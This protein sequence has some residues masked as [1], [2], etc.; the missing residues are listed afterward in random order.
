MSLCPAPRNNAFSTNLDK[1]SYGDLNVG[2][3]TRGLGLTGSSLSLNIQMLEYFINLFILNII[4]GSILEEF[5][6]RIREKMFCTTQYGQENKEINLSL[7]IMYFPEL[8]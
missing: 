6:I 8:Y 4:I 3:R 5:Q 2:F 7:N 1:L